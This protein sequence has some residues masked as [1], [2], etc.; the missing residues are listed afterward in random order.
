MPSAQGV[1]SENPH[2]TA[3]APK[4]EDRRQA[5]NKK[6]RP[7]NPCSRNAQRHVGVQRQPLS[8]RLAQ[9]FGAGWDAVGAPV[10]AGGYCMTT[11]PC[12]CHRCIAEN[13]LTVEMLGHAVPLS[14]AKMILCP[15]CGNKRCPHASDHRLPCTGSNDPGQPGS[16]Y[17]DIWSKT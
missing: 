14:M 9:A 8:V 15:V 13:N 16:V 3:T 7:A 11:T 17:V 2:P 5:H 4:T 12:E 10:T 6:A 1:A